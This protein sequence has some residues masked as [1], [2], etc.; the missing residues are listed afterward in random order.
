MF[1]IEVIVRATKHDVLIKR[2][3]TSDALD[4]DCHVGPGGGARRVIEVGVI[5]RAITRESP[6]TGTSSRFPQPDGSRDGRRGRANGDARALGGDR[7][8]ALLERL[9]RMLNRGAS[10]GTPQGPINEK[11]PES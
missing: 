8:R 6:S 2:K 4:V 5:A 9:Q 11:C 3:I 1:E 7:A 10:R